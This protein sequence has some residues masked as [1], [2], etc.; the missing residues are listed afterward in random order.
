M[1]TV[2]LTIFPS[3]LWALLY[4]FQSTL[5]AHFI[6]DGVWMVQGVHSAPQ[7]REAKVRQNWIAYVSKESTLLRNLAE[8][9]FSEE[10]LNKIRKGRQA[11]AWAV[12]H[13]GTLGHGG[14]GGAVQAACRHPTGGNSTQVSLKKVLHAYDLWPLILNLGVWKLCHMKPDT[15]YRSEGKRVWWGL[16][17]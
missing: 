7:T 4:G 13:S 12:P 8:S 15:F 6:H 9:T 3:S 17:A 14:V 11:H 16:Y 5:V 1:I 2:G 10:G